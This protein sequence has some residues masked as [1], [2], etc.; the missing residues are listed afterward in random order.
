ML[1]PGQVIA[2]GDQRSYYEDAGLSGGYLDWEEVPPWMIGSNV[3]K[4]DAYRR[5]S[6][7]VVRETASEL[8]EKIDYYNLCENQSFI[9]IAEQ[10]KNLRNALND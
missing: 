2:E 7:K 5:P 9:L 6:D 8:I 3:D 4:P 10:I 1:N